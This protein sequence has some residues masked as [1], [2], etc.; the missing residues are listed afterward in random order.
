M[1]LQGGICLSS[2]GRPVSFE[3]A[4]AWKVLTA[5]RECSLYLLHVHQLVF[6]LKETW[7]QHRM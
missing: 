6:C 7:T 5:M 2:M 4:V 1:C 3:R